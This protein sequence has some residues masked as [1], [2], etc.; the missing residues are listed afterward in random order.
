MTYYEIWVE[1]FWLI[2]ENAVSLRSKVQKSVKRIHK[3][4]LF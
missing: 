4:E 3:T 1:I 2:Q